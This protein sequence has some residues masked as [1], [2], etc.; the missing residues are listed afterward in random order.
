MKLFG[1][2]F[3]GDQEVSDIGE[4]ES[5]ISEMSHE[6]NQIFVKEFHKAFEEGDRKVE[7]AD[8]SC[9]V[10]LDYIRT[11]D[12]IMSNNDQDKIDQILTAEPRKKKGDYL[13]TSNSK[14]S[15]DPQEML[16]RTYDNSENV[17]RKPDIKMS[18]KGIYIDSTK[19]MDR[20]VNNNV[21]YENAGIK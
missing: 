20:F 2:K 4:K 10:D 3:Y 13:Q 8:A 12:I 7:Q 17:S 1:A 21:L 15:V 6:Y 19:S 5:N 11:S 18:T 16:E 14:R 9:Q